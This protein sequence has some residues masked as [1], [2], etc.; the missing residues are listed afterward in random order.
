MKTPTWA[1]QTKQ[2]QRRI[3]I[4]PFAV[5]LLAESFAAHREVW[6]DGTLLVIGMGKDRQPVYICISSEPP[7]EDYRI[8]AINDNALIVTVA[9]KE[10]P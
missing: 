8:K 6:E 7:A 10:N 4:N 9:L 3:G 2:Q 5:E 1:A